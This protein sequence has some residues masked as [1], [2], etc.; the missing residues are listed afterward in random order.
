MQPP[1]K[2]HLV[3][4][5]RLQQGK[6]SLWAPSPLSFRSEPQ[7][8]AADIVHLHD[9]APNEVERRQ[10]ASS[11]TAMA[12]TRAGISPRRRTS[13]GSR[14]AVHLQGPQAPPPAKPRGRRGMATGQT[15]SLRIGEGRIWGAEMTHGGTGRGFSRAAGPGVGSSSPVRAPGGRRRTRAR[16]PASG[17]GGGAKLV[18]LSSDTLLEHGVCKHG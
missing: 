17:R 13:M 1:N 2:Q 8:A 4:F 16:S 6:R 9:H 5:R 7:Q 12:E 18:G 14:A 11:W 10:T 15:L 3:H